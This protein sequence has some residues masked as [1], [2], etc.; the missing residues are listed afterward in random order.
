MA[1]ATWLAG[2]VASRMGKITAHEKR[3]N[4]SLT[5]RYAAMLCAKASTATLQHRRFAYRK[6]DLCLGSVTQDGSEPEGY[7][8]VLW[9]KLQY[10]GVG[11]WTGFSV[12]R[13]ARSGDVIWLSAAGIAT[14]RTP[15]PEQ[16]GPGTAERPPRPGCTGGRKV[17][18][19]RVLTGYSQGSRMLGRAISGCSSDDS[20]RPPGRVWAIAQKASPEC[21]QR[22][23]A[24]ANKSKRSK[25]DCIEQRKPESARDTAR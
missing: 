23:S 11:D 25:Q 16:A 20:H 7:N 8:Q 3:M 6:D 21:T 1:C 17:S 9:D 5:S 4:R 22:T 2:C 10:L 18:P 19:A 24:R 13:P 15:D 12:G 14:G